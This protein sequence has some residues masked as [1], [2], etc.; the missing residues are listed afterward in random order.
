MFVE[1]LVLRRHVVATRDLFVQAVFLD[2]AKEVHLM[3]SSV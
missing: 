3:G 1:C 2:T